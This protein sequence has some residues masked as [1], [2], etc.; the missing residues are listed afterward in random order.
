[1][2]STTPDISG[3]AFRE[4]NGIASNAFV[5]LH[6]GNIGDKQRLE[7]VIQASKHLEGQRDIQFV[8]V[9]DGARKAAVVAEAI[10]LRANNVTFLPLQ[11][12]EK[13]AQMLASADVLALHQHAG[14]T[15]SVIPSKLL[16]YMASGNPI[17]A[18]AAPDSGT[19]RLMEL[20]GCG[21]IVEPEKPEA[22]AEAIRKFAED[23]NLGA[24]CG[25][26]GRNFCCK[27]F[28]REV[29]LSRLESLLYEIAGI[30]RPKPQQDRSMH[31]AA[32][33]AMVPGDAAGPLA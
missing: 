33:P 14:V 18:T 5:V 3:K 8:I 22:F 20:A 27:N 11:P 15:D 26:S 1:M 32:K 28:S 13:F 16:A 19:R 4:K 29:V 23:R 31:L 25:A 6:A 7:L 10:R 17:V 30:P 2:E 24:R 9:G 12:E 21:L